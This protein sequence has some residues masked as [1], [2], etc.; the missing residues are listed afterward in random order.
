MRGGAAGALVVVAGVGAG[1]VAGT[2]L[3]LALGLSMPDALTLVSL[4]YCYRLAMAAV[5]GLWELLGGVRA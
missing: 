1:D 3:Y 4:L 2:G 5:G